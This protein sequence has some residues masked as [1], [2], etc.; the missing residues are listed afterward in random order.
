MLTA[1]CDDN[2]SFLRRCHFTIKIK[3]KVHIFSDIDLSYV[4]TVKST[5]EI[6]QNFVAFSE[7]MNSSKQ[8]LMLSLSSYGFH[9]NA[10]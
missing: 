2:Q 6:S 7:Y 4:V 9:G 10:P 8:T 3:V 5:L 1:S